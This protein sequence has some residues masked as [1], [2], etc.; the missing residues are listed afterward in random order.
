MN[1]KMGNWIKKIEVK[2]SP[3]KIY[4]R[5]TG[6]FSVGLK[7]LQ[8]Q[9][10]ILTIEIEVEGEKDKYILYH[11]RTEFG[12]WQHH[13]TAQGRLYHNMLRKKFRKVV[14]K[15]KEEVVADFSSFDEFIE[16]IISE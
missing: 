7:N 10:S 12:D 15:I 4:S 1:K 5:T 9:K 6:H 3:I 14:V 8:S 2:I 13:M 11:D 16:T